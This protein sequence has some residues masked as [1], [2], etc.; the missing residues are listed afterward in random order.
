MEKWALNCGF[1]SQMKFSSN[2]ICVESKFHFKWFCAFIFFFHSCPRA[3]KASIRI[4]FFCYLQIYHFHHKVSFTIYMYHF[5]ET[6]WH[7]YIW[8]IY[9]Y[10]KLINLHLYWFNSVSKNSFRLNF[11][12]TL[13]KNSI[14]TVQRIQ[15]ISVH[16]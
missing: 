11:I 9:K 6:F 15:F 16:V 14:K 2:D 5:D 4:S 1:V 7:P 8:H 13:L 12:F 10:I 3:E